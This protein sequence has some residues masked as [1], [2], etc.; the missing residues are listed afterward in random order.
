VSIPDEER[1]TRKRK[2]HHVKGYTHG[3]IADHN[4]VV[5]RLPASSK[6]TTFSFSLLVICDAG[7]SSKMALREVLAGVSGA[8]RMIYVL[9]TWLSVNAARY[10]GVVQWDFGKVEGTGRFQRT[11]TLNKPPSVLLHALQSL[12]TYD[13]RDGIKLEEAL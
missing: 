5:A 4:V 13:I 10:M 12:K 7:F 6:S 2:H 1:H 8:R 3:W 9:E 11:A